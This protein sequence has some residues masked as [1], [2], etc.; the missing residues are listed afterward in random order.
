M[1]Y[2]ID[3]L[4]TSNPVDVDNSI[5]VV[6]NRIPIDMKQELSSDF[7]S[8]GVEEAMKSMKIISSHGPDGL[9][10][11]SYQTYWKYVGSESSS[12]LFKFLIKGVT[13]LLLNILLL[14]LFPKCLTLLI[15]LNLGLLVYVMLSLK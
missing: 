9:T 6:S 5:D 2:F 12:L 3:I 7:T 13:Q 10:T 8:E 15:P 4:S 11:L 14:C 1:N